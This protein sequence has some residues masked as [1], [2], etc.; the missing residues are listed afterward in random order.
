MNESVSKMH[1][2]LVL[3]T[4]NEL[5]S[6]ACM[7]NFHVNFQHPHKTGFSD[8]IWKSKGKFSR[9]VTLMDGISNGDGFVDNLRRLYMISF[10]E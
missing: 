10:D 6:E 1:F 4:K 9:S 3:E 8:E 5:S 2:L 7:E